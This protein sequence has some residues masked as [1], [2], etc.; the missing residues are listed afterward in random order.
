[1]KLAS[2][3]ST[4]SVRYPGLVPVSAWGETSLFYNPQNLFERGTYCVTFKEKDGANDSASALNREEVD[5]RMNFKINKETFLSRFQ[6]TSL[7]K[8]PPKGHVIQLQSGSAYD[9]T[10]LDALIPHP[11]YGWMGWV[12]ITNPSANSVRE[13]LDGGLLDESY[14]HAVKSYDEKKRKLLKAN[15]GADKEMGSSKLSGRK[16]RSGD[17]GGADAAVAESKEKRQGR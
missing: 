10:V 1:M 11:V 5:F 7:P 17:E 12:S 15:N 4:L 3:I 8:R 2:L 13:I 14:S 6:E 9:P 16:R